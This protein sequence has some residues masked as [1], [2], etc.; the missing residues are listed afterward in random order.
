M[1]IDFDAQF[2]SPG[3]AGGRYARC[4]AGL[5]SYRTLRRCC[6]WRMD[7]LESGRS[8]FYGWEVS[9][10]GLLAAWPRGAV[11]VEERATY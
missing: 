7:N 4:V 8:T 3:S 11:F 6:V 1:E 10:E 5:K 9:T 2:E